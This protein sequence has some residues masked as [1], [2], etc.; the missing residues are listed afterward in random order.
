MTS[1]ELRCQVCLH[2]Y[3]KAEQREPGVCPFCGTRLT[4]M[5]NS[6]AGYVRLHWQQ[7]RMLALYA[8][9]WADQFS[10]QKRGNRDSIQALTNIINHLRKYRPQ[11]AD[12]IGPDSIQAQPQDMPVT[13]LPD[14]SV[15]SPYFARGKKE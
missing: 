11:G 2:D 10:I 5:L 3:S 12:D 1:R 9:R 7:V 13:R 4:P 14:G 8:R 15:Q 6:Q